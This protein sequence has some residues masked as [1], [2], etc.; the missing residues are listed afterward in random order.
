MTAIIN[1]PMISASDI[2]HELDMAVAAVRQETRLSQ[3]PYTLEYLRGVK[4]GLSGFRQY[5]RSSEFI[6]LLKERNAR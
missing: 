1:R 4:D 6:E 3:A 5:V 2:Y